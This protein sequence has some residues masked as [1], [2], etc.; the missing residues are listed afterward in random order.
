MPFED[1]QAPAKALA[2]PVDA[3]RSRRPRSA[4]GSITEMADALFLAPDASAVSRIA[5]SELTSAVDAAF[6]IVVKDDG[7]YRHTENARAWDERAFDRLVANIRAPGDTAEGKQIRVIA[8]AVDAELG[9]KTLV[10]VP[11]QHGDGATGTLVLGLAERDTLSEEECDL[12]IASASLIGHA[13]HHVRMEERRRAAQQSMTYIERASRL[14]GHGTNREEALYE[15]A[16]MALPRLGDYAIID[17]VGPDGNAMQLGLAHVKP[18]MERVLRE[19]RARYPVSLANR[20]SPIRRAIATREPVVVTSVSANV[21]AD[22]ATSPDHLRELEQINPTAFVIVPLLL[23]GEVLGTMSFCFANS[24]RRFTAP[25]VALAAALGDRVSSVLYSMSLI[26]TSENA[27]AAAEESAAQLQVHVGAL[28]ASNELLQDQAVELEQQTEE[29]QA[30]A[31]ELEATV[32]QLQ[33]SEVRFRALVDASAQAVWRSDIHGIVSEA[34]DSWENLTGSRIQPTGATARESAVHPDDRE[35]TTAAWQH[36]L[37]TKTPY[38]IEHRIRLADG[39]Y[40]WFLGRAVPIRDVSGQDVLEWVGMHTDIHD[41]HVT[42][43]EQRLLLDVS[44]AIQSESDPDRMVQKVLRQMVDYLA[45]S[46]ARLIEVDA[47]EATALLHDAHVVHRAEQR[48]NER[49]PVLRKYRLADI[50]TDVAGQVRGEAFIVFDTMHDPR[51]APFFDSV[52]AAHETRATMSVP[53]MRGGKWIAALSVASDVPREWT[54]RE[55]AFVRRVG[56][57]LWPAF[58][59]ARAFIDLERARSEAE[60]RAVESESLSAE[61]AKTNAELA[62]SESRLAGVVGSAMDAIIS[63]D[64]DGRINLF[65]AAAERIFGVRVYDAVG[66]PLHRFVQPAGPVVDDGGIL[67]PHLGAVRVPEPVVGRR[68]DGTAFPAEATI[69]QVGGDAGHFTTVV[70]RDVTERRALEVQLLQ[71]QKMEAVGRLAGGVAHDFNNILTVIRSCADFLRESLPESDD[72]RVDVDEVLEATDR[73][74][75]LTRQLL[76]FSRKQ[77]VLA[78]VLDLNMV[79]RGI[80]P[81][82][83][84]LIGEDIELA[85]MLQGK[86]LAVRADP[87]Q[88]EQVII[89]LA[90]NARDAMTKGG[91]LGIETDV[92]A[93]TEHDVRRLSLEPL[94]ASQATRPG[95]YAV[96]R[97]TDTG[98]GIDPEV[99]KHVFEPFFTTKAEGHG[100]GLGLATVHGIAMQAGGHVKV[101]SVSHEGTTFEVLFP[102]LRNEDS[103]EHQ[104]VIPVEHPRASGRILLVED[105]VAVRRSVRRMLE[106]TGYTVLEARHGADALLVWH[107]HKAAID[108]LITDLRMPELGGRE[109]MAALHAIRPDLPVIAMSGYPPDVGSAPLETWNAGGRTQFLAKPFSTEVL[110]SAVE[111]LLHP[112]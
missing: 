6:V 92:V 111:H 69:S 52:F 39:S 67:A 104:P 51:T 48:P 40:R 13:H 43:A 91:V 15:L 88:L 9:V 58:E 23:F 79:V 80:E 84:R 54:S 110:L 50:S 55:I 93:L 4:I 5:A 109:L 22:L 11:F 37:A 46:H 49:A 57:R 61:L 78:R 73:A 8:D 24:E 63:V 66:E 53:L 90:V 99:M 60:R 82:L 7:V 20:R 29:A 38:E 10:M 41:K 108:L 87:G 96:I 68:A 112:A 107:E 103:G 42:A 19:Y 16:R 74:S 62:G 45:L 75:A 65:N 95:E 34:S 18:E 81:M 3:I 17:I 70:L 28:A 30:L 31:E 100:T 76:M 85:V 98:A 33:K 71:S 32:D 35:R 89:N 59:A 44:T 25:D 105:E 86:R 27:R 72:R 12:L 36:A 83:R 97:V 64:G 56:A 47:D 1:S 77:V 26:E 2:G 94:T 101:R 14:L 21:L 102:F 106:R